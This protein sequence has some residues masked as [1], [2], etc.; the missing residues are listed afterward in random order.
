VKS[1]SWDGAEYGVYDGSRAN[2]NGIEF[3]IP[4]GAVNSWSGVNVLPL[5]RTWI[6]GKSKLNGR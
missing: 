3:V 2:G 4:G 1:Q 6:P 5:S